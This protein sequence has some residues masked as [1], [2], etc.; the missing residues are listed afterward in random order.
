MCPMFAVVLA[1]RDADPEIA[2]LARTLDR[3]RLTGAAQLADT[4][5]RR[6]GVDDPTRLAEIRDTI[7]TMN[8]PQLYGLLVVQRGWSPQRYGA[9]I[10]RALVALITP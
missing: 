6:L 5:G 1:A 8:S 3:H 4:V 2:E 7:W 9:W 10:A